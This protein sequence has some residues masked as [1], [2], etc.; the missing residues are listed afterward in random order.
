MENPATWT[1]LHHEINKAEFS[2]SDKA[3]AI[4]RVLHS[5]N[6]RVT[7]DQVQAVINRNNEQNQLHICG[8]SLPS[9]IVNELAREE[10]Q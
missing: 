5:H 4:L 3:T 10:Y 2:S 7:L 9:M 6:Y 1:P 8:L